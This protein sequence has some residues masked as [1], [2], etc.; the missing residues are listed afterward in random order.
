MVVDE[1]SRA[2]DWFSG[3]EGPMMGSGTLIYS[4]D[5]MAV[6]LNSEGDELSPAA[7]ALGGILFYAGPFEVHGESVIHKVVNASHP[8]LK[9]NFARK[10]EFDTDRTTLRL[11]GSLGDG[12]EVVVEWKRLV[13]DE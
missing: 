7:A 11:V 1:Q 9:K 2:L 13:S 12:R 3:K 4:G 8:T 5:H 10:V 6:S